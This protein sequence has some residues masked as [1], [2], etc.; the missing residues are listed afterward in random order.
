MI[1]EVLITGEKGGSQAKLLI[2]ATVIAG[3]YDFLVT[4]FHVWKESLDYQ[5]L[6]AVRT[7]TERARVAVS[8]DAISFILGLGYVMG[9]RSS[10]ILCAGGVFSNIVLVP[11][12]WMIGSHISDVAVYPGAGPIAHDDRGADAL[13]QL[14]PL[15]RSRRHRHRG[16]FRDS[17]I[18]E[19]RRWVVRRCP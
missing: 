10:L 2:E 7:L 9:L 1:T 13:P 8:F 15:H 18:D 5:F 4:T 11:L 6:P 17:Q 19:N 14:C 12:I 16:H 3:I